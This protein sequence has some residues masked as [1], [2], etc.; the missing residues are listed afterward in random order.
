MNKYEETV[1]NDIRWQQRYQNFQSAVELLHE[2]FERRLDNLSDLEREG[3]VRRFK[4]ALELAWKTMKD[5]LQ[6]SGLLIDPV[7]PRNVIKEAFS[8]KVITEG[9][10]WIA[11]L[12]YWNLLS[13]TYSS[14]NFEKAVIAIQDQYLSAFDGL[15]LWLFKHTTN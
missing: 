12:D 1:P 15:N 9:E 11:M 5:Y 8:A 2:P 13:H 7:T 10:V 4:F 14:R 3:T 6:F